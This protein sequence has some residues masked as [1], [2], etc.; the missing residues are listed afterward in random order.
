MTASKLVHVEEA[1]PKLQFLA[2]NRVACERGGFKSGM[3]GFAARIMKLRL[4]RGLESK[5]IPNYRN[6]LITAAEKD[7]I[8]SDT[9][10]IIAEICGFDKA[11]PAWRIGKKKAFEDEY[12]GVRFLVERRPSWSIHRAVSAQIFFHQD[13]KAAEWP[14]D[15]EVVCEK[16][17][18]QEIGMTISINRAEA[19][20]TW[21]EADFPLPFA[22]RARERETQIEALSEILNKKKV[23][24]TVLGNDR[25]PA[26]ELIHAE[27]KQLG[28]VPLDRC[29][30]LYG[31]EDGLEVRLTLTVYD[32]DLNAETPASAIVE[33]EEAPFVLR[34]DGQS[35]GPNKT[36]VLQAIAVRSLKQYPDQQ[37]GSALLAS[38]IVKFQKR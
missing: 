7:K 25:S 3:S 26:W 11:S 37:H 13:G 23:D 36:K 14:F 31:I 9:E 17:E 2:S 1:L 15:I 30:K 18:L 19:R 29:C 33:E 6:T 35:L 16:A 38:D 10:I 28:I 32:K 12:T 5:E 24:V 20:V 21:S 4:E 8:D 27:R 22:S 34:A